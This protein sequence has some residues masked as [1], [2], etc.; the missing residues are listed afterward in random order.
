VLSS[1]QK[2]VEVQ[3]KIIVAAREL[4][5]SFMRHLFTYGPVPL[6][7]ADQVPLKET[8][9][10]PTPEDWEMVRLGEVVTRKIT[11][12]THKTPNYRPRGIPFVTAKDLSDGKVDFS[13][14]RFISIDEHKELV[15]RC[16]PEK[17]DILLSKVGTLGLVSQVDIDFEFSIFVQLALI[18]PKI[19]RIS[20]SYL[21]FALLS[22]E[23]QREILRSS[24]QSTMRYIGVGKIA[25]L[26]IPL[27][28]LPE[29]RE[30]ARILSVVDRKIEAEERR[31]AVLQTLFK[32]MLHHLI[33]GKIRVMETAASA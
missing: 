6:D 16:N 24:S 22:L 4:K 30:I 8:E 25:N 29:Q 7:Q 17:G 12:G 21:K 1:I 9:I 23:V 2:A 18:K 15:R 32:T 19:S 3:D 11:D 33:T 27:P 20:P 5:R 26:P 10:G 14:C 13:Q 31:K 28:P